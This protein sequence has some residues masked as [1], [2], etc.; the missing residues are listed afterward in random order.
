M[1]N[2]FDIYIKHRNAPTITYSKD[3]RE[4]KLIN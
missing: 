4:V 2:K 1:Y 3:E